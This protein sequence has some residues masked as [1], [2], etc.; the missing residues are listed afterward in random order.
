MKGMLDFLE[1][2]GLVTKDTPTLPPTPLADPAVS[3]DLGLEP[4]DA[5]LS[6]PASHAESI[7][8]T[9][10][11]AAPL[12]L[13]AIYAREGVPS[14]AYPAERLLRLIDGLSA[15]DESTRLMAINAMDAADESWTISDP[16]ADA[17]AKA[18]ALER[19]T[20]R[21]LKA[22]QQSEHEASTRRSALS[23]RRDKVVGD[24]RKQIAELEALMER[25]QSRAA[26]EIAAQDASV[27]AARSQSSRELSAVAQVREKLRGLARQFGAPIE[28]PQE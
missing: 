8:S 12:Q 4:A 20:E 10:D 9:P 24:V 13:D 15:M 19:H 27:Q 16:L 23:A 22:M 5:G 21:Q 18:Q 11:A 25:E 1:K 26:S 7:E 3:A 28:S 17:H 14:A 6:A 2:A